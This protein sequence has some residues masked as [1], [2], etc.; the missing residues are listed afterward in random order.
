MSV[1]ECPG[2]VRGKVS[3]FDRYVRAMS[4]TMSGIL[5]VTEERLK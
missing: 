5:V 2:I 1:R 3:G 4:G